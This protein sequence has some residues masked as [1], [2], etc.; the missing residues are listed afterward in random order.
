MD[1]T[2]NAADTTDVMP[3][4]PALDALPARLRPDTRAMRDWMPLVDCNIGLALDTMKTRAGL[5]IGTL[6]RQ[7][8]KRPSVFLSWW[9]RQDAQGW[10]GLS[11]VRFLAL[12]QACRGKVTV[13]FP[14]L[15]GRR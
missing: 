13:E 12:V 9:R 10:R 1:T 2:P 11:L 14:H 8:G 3:D 5:P 15:G 6:G 7:F 4:S